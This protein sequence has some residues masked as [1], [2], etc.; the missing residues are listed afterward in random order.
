SV[1]IAL[2]FTGTVLAYVDFVSTAG[3]LP[4]ALNWAVIEHAAP[5]LH[6][7]LMQLAF[8]FILV[9]Y[10]TKAGLAPMHTWLPDAHSEAPSSISAM[11]SGVLLAVGVY[12]IARWKTVVDASLGPEFTNRML[13]GF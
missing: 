13:I 2:A 7:E 4:G 12:A 11:M 8:A 9:G 6:P 5:S 10:G 3:R 1:G